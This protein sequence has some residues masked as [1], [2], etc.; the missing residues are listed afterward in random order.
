MTH[1]LKGICVCYLFAAASGCSVGRRHTP[2]ASLEQNFSR[3]EAEFE[4]LV[5]SVKADAKLQMIASNE[6]RYGDRVVSG[7]SPSES[8]RIGMDSQR[9]QSYRAALRRLDLVQITQGEG[10]V[11]FKVDQEALLNGN[12]EKGYWYGQQPPGRQVASLDNYRICEDD[13]DRFGDYI[14]SKPL[15]G[16]WYVYL[17]VNGR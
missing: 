9:W 1:V 17:L 12:S 10:A 4:A 16:H 8:E 15:R 14:V 6:I 11:V 3:H 13:R 7:D 5:A 2:D